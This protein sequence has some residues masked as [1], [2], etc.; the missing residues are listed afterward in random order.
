MQ[1]RIDP[2]TMKLL[3]GFAE[4]MGEMQQQIAQLGKMI[5]ALTD[6]MSTMVKVTDSLERETRRLKNQEAQGVSVRSEEV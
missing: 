2:I 4:E 1:G 5:I 6:T 3:E